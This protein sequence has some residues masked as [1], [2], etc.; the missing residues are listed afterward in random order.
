MADGIESNHKKIKVLWITNIPSPYRV[1]FF[2]GLGEKVNL[3]VLFEKGKS[4]ERDA[5]WIQNKFYNF[6]AV[7]L[8]GITLRTDSAFNL[9][10]RKYLKQAKQY[11]YV[12]V[13]NPLTIT[14]MYSIQYLKNHKIPF[15]IETD[16]GFPKDGSGFREKL[17]KYFIGA[18]Q[19]WLS[20]AEI[21]SQ[22]YLQYGANK[23]NI[24]KYPF[25]S[26]RMDTVLDIPVSIEDKADLR[27]ELGIQ[28]E[29]I[30]LAIGQFIPRKGF[31]VLLKVANRLDNN[32]A[33]VLLGGTVT[34]EYQQIIDSEQLTNVYFPGFI[35]RNEIQKYY[36]VADLFVL[37]TREDIWGL[38][39]NEAIAVGLPV[40]TTERCIAGTELIIQGKNGFVVPVDNDEKLFEAIRTIIQD[41]LLIKAMSIES[42]KVAKQYTIETMVEWH[43]RFFE[44][45]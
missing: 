4:D 34:E 9:K 21:H 18:A 26:V 23:E 31:D 28:Q 45:R 38:V 30:I 7:I 16:G 40:V 14:G 41:D 39:I 1:D 22:Y 33:V 43:E 5:S 19:G 6:K 11:D 13:S 3:T 37:P 17:K 8:N 27:A 24:F 29:K 35:N 36:R 42:L 20:T 10:I 25:T 44:S 12:V 32:I 2:E 15:Y